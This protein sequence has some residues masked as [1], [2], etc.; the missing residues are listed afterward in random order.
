MKEKE[1]RPSERP[2]TAFVLALLAGLWMLAVG[3][4]MA[5]FNWG[6]GMMGGW[7]WGH[8]MMGG[9]APSPFW[10]PWF[11]IIAG[12]VVL[13]GAAMLYARPEQRQGWG[14]VILVA[15]A[16]NLLIGIGGVLASLLGLI[17]GALALAR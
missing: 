1:P 9:L 11:G 14:I 6:P 10:W 17:G 13:V 15:S 12:I 3:G 7:M 16:L 4:M 8:G 5:G 2:I